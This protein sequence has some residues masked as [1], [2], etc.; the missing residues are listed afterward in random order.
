MALAGAMVTRL[1]ASSKER[2]GRVPVMMIPV[3]ASPT[4]CGATTGGQ[5]RAPSTSIHR[6]ARPPSLGSCFPR[7]LSPFGP[8]RE[9]S[10][11]ALLVW[12]GVRARGAAGGM[13]N[14]HRPALWRLPL[15]VGKLRALKLRDRSSAQN[16]VCSRDYR[17][18]DLGFTCQAAC[19]ARAARLAVPLLQ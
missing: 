11:L 1:R 8:P 15:A 7:P 12:A 17:N 9:V 19:R 13:G 16:G 5:P 18:L 10:Y 2:N 3:C 14:T 4:A 6:L